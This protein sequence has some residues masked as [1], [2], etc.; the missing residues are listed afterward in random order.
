MAAERATQALSTPPM[1]ETILLGYTTLE[2]LCEK[3]WKKLHQKNG[4]WMES[5]MNNPHDPQ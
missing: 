5:F 2:A 3:R 1:T 4:V